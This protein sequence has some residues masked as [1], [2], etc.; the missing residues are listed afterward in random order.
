MKAMYHWRAVNRRNY[1]RAIGDREL[2]LV[3]SDE[4]AKKKQDSQS[5]F[6]GKLMAVFGGNDTNEFPISGYEMQRL[7][8]RIGVEPPSLYKKRELYFL[9]IEEIEMLLKKVGKQL[10]KMPN[11]EPN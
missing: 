6:L 7:V 2:L 5:A 1:A 9:P 10:E 11:R 8:K 4:L 3:L